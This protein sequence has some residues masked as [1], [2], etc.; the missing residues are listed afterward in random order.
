LPPIQHRSF[1]EALSTITDGR[2][3]CGDFTGAYCTLDSRCSDYRSLLSD[4][5][6]KIAFTDS[7]PSDHYVRVPLG[8]FANDNYE[9][10]TCNIFV[11]QQS[12]DEKGHDI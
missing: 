6:F 5:S 8:A 4:Y 11:Q 1:A 7:T 9:H 12:G 10:D 2:S 3:N